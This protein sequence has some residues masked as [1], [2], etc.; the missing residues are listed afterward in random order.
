M[1]DKD[2]RNAEVY[3]TA[4]NREPVG[5]AHRRAERPRL[6]QH[7][8]V[9]FPADVI[10][11][12][13]RLAD[14]DGLTVSAWIRHLVTQEVARRS[15]VTSQTGPSP[16]SQDLM[17]ALKFEVRERS[18]SETVESEGEATLPEAVTG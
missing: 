2:D 13:R 12:V 6:G 15:R 14:E 16:E 10:D 9:R 17:E 18:Q 4:A 5:P 7:V 8:P 3:E 11:R 1:T